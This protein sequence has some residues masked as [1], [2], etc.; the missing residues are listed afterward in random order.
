MIPVFDIGD[1]LVESR[2]F[3]RNFFREALKDRG[4]EDVPE[5]PF[6]RF[7]EFKASDVERWLEE[8]DVEADAGELVKDFRA[9]KRKQFMEQASELLA[10]LPVRPGFI[11]DNSVEAKLFFRD[12]MVSQGIDFRGFVVSEEVGE[13]K[14]SREIFE[15][16]LQRRDV[17]GSRCVYFGNRADIDSGC[18]KAGMEFVHVTRFDTF[19]TEWE[20][21]TVSELTAEEVK[22]YL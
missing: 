15:A 19:G 20:G 9:E 10:D 3:A 21:E 12:L 6:E 11:S 7:N 4:I 17:E 5:Y 14:P 2:G 22:R 8:N 16:F 13:R 18:E 1:T